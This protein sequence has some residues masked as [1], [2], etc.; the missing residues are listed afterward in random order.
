LGIKDFGEA[1]AMSEVSQWFENLRAIQG[2]M[3]DLNHET[4]KDDL[5]AFSKQTLALLVS[6]LHQ[7]N[8]CSFCQTS[9]IGFCRKD[10]FIDNTRTFRW[11]LDEIA[12]PIH[13]IMV[14]TAFAI[15]RERF[16]PPYTGM[17]IKKFRLEKVASVCVGPA[18]QTMLTSLLFADVPSLFYAAKPDLVAQALRDGWTFDQLCE[19]IV[20]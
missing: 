9:K 1:T 17:L 4:N 10:T 11:F 19:E 8:L 16:V 18:N 20:K 2:R 5:Y 3:A 7:Q 13:E 6:D 15:A 14:A 12:T